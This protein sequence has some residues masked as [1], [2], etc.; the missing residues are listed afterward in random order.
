[1]KINYLYGFIAFM[2]L[3]SLNA[4]AADSYNHEGKVTSQSTKISALGFELVV[5]DGKKY[6]ID[7]ELIVHSNGIKEA[8]FSEGRRIGF[9]IV[10]V[11]NKV[12]TLA[13]IWILK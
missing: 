7:N 13:E 6:R 8:Y 2:M 12:P 4:N 9:N 11:E 5:I 3:A 10:D 1:M